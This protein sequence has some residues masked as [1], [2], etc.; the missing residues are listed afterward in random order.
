[1]QSVMEELYY[2]NIRPTERNYRKNSP[3]VRAAKLTSDIYEKL[4]VLLN[5]EQ[6]ELFEKY[7]DAQEELESITRYDTFSYALKFGILLIAETF[8]GM[9]EVTGTGKVEL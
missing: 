9:R 7:C 4:M 1:M 8:V 5:E 2:G 3:F 6:K